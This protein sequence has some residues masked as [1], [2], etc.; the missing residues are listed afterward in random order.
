[1][2]KP[3]VPNE[4]Y[5]ESISQELN[6]GENPGWGGRIMSS[7]PAF[8]SLNY[9]LYFFGQLFS[10]VGTWLQI[11]AEGWLVYQL[12]N[13]AFFVGLDAAAS[14]IPTLFLSLV[15]GVIIDRY[16]KKKILL[17]TQTASMLLALTLA[18]LTLSHVITVWEIIALA[19]GLGIVNAIDSPTRQAYV[20]ELIDRRESL[21]SAIALNAGMFNA[22]R[23]VG[24]SIAGLLIASVGAGMAFLLNGISYIAVIVA[25]SR[26]STPMK[27]DN[28]HLHPIRAIKDG[29]RYAYGH[30]VIR[31]LIVLTGI[32]SVFG[33][34]YSTLMP[35][36]ARNTFHLDAAGL[37]YLYASAG[38]GALVGTFCIS[39]FSRRV[40]IVN[41][42]IGGNLLFSVSLIAF[43]FTSSAPV[44][45]ILLFVVGL[46]I[47]TQF[48]LSNTL[49]QHQ[50]DDAMRGRVLSL[51]TLV[52]IGFGPFGNVE[53]GYVSERVGTA[54]A[55]RIS[56]VIVLL[57]G[58]YLFS[59]R[60]AL[61]AHTDNHG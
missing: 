61:I 60:R 27:A 38:L 11:V 28:R 9:R 13:S 10:L 15:G 31:T 22:A 46:G 55:I 16:P 47:V 14:T 41:V 19:F 51:Y 24:P 37:G 21:A 7:F 26:I 54:M 2:A 44:A 39:A 35:V 20:T 1:M 57:F 23:V 4:T 17:F 36:I 12:T 33:W 42:I 34:S 49:L 52:F 25:L 32:V 6:V 30:T 45:F 8:R 48:A 53:I 43:T 40:N 29:I 18:V 3:S 58:L 50:V 59:K 56:A 5:V